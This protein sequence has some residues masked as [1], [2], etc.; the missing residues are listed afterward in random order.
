MKNCA[1]LRLRDPLYDPRVR[2]MYVLRE[3][4]LEGPIRFNSHSPCELFIPLPVRSLKL[5]QLLPHSF[6]LPL[7]SR[8][9]S[10]AQGGVIRRGGH[11]RRCVR[12][13]SATMGR[14]DIGGWI[15]G[16]LDICEVGRLKDM[17]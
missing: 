17:T 4:V 10:I 11:G 2:L 1:Y 16:Y 12:A 15:F 3:V 8:Q 13:E 5:V 7:L 9:A 6:Q 14:S